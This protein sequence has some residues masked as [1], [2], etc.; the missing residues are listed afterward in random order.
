MS[1]SRLNNVIIAARTLT[2]DMKC[3]IKRFLESIENVELY[4]STW[5]ELIFLGEKININAS[6]SYYTCKLQCFIYIA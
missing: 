5:T 4:I 2:A 6:L 1:R 3:L